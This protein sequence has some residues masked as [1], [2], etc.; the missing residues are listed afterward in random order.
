M[1][2]ISNKD[3]PVEWGYVHPEDNYDVDHKLVGHAGE[4]EKFLANSL[5]AL[6]N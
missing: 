3:F 5:S 1:I 4:T 6:E 2:D